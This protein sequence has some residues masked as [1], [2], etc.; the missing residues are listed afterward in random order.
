VL[1]EVPTARLFL[2]FKGGEDPTLCAHYRAKLQAGG[3]APERVTIGGILPLAEHYALY[4]QVDIAL[5]T[6]PYHGTTTTC[7]ALWMGVPVVTLVGE[8]H[9]SRVGLSLLTRVGLKVFVATTPDDYVKKAC[10]AAHAR[11][12]LARLRACLR[13]RMRASPLMDAPGYAR[14]IEQAYRA[15]WR[16]WCESIDD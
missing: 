5:D 14:A 13:E 15:M 11:E 12:P 2:K 3:V 8:H 4:H 10:G 16:Q 7:E 6:F 9:A 1:R